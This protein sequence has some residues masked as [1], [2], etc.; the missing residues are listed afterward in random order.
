MMMYKPNKRMI[1]RS[2][3]EGLWIQYKT[4]PHQVQ[5]HAKINQLQVKINKL[6]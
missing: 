6:M 3:Q 4:S 5:L 1:R 2:F